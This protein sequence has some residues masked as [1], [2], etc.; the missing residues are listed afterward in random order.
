MELY[1]RIKSSDL[2]LGASTGVKTRIGEL[3]GI[4]HYHST[5]ADRSL[6]QVSVHQSGKSEGVDSALEPERKDEADLAL[7]E[8]VP[9]TL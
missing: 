6:F 1:K 2:L 4:C 7:T 5:P 9:H 8:H 3:R